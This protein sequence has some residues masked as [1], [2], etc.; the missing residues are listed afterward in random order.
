[1]GLTTTGRSYSASFKYRQACESVVI[2]HQLQFIQHHHYLLVSSGPD[3][4]FVEV[5]R[6]FADLPAKMQTLLDDSELAERIARN[7]ASTFR[8]RYLTPAAEACYWRALVQGWMD[9]SP[10]LGGDIVSQGLKEKGVRYESFLLMSSDEM[11]R[12]TSGWQ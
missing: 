11:L 4:N 10:E 2:A 7:S 9:A 5:Q 8:D 12:F 6:D 3:Q 1:M